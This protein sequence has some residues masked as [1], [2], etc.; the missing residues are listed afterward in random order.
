MEALC[1]TETSVDKRA[2]RRNIP[3]DAILYSHRRENLKSYK[4][5]VALHIF[6]IYHLT[7]DFMLITSRSEIFIHQTFPVKAQKISLVS[8]HQLLL[9]L[10]LNLWLALSKGPNKVGVFL[11]SLKDGKRS[12]FRKVSF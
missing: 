7:S 3:E 4:V 10:V 1:T 11:P 5:T 8:Y 6:H 9:L 2:T 12:S